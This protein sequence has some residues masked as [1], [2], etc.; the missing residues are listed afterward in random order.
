[1]L[2]MDIEAKTGVCANCGPVDI[3]HIGRGRF[4]CGVARRSHRDSPNR[5]GG[6]WGS[7]PRPHGLTTQEAKKLRVGKTC[8]LRGC[9]SSEKLH[10]DHCHATK[11]LRDV[12]CSRHNQGLGFFHDSISELEAAIEYLKRHS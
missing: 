10:V 9:D 4:R 1:M 11:K 5:N 3:S 7:V 8:A 2:S 12:L 6:D